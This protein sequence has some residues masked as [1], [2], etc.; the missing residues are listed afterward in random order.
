MENFFL[1]TRGDRGGILKILSLRKGANS[2]RGAYFKL[3]AYSSIY[4]IWKWKNSKINLLLLV[5][6]SSLSFNFWDKRINFE[7]DSF[8]SP[9]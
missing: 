9:D 5:G 8:R 7:K 3:G 6:V 4:G 1:R 2:K